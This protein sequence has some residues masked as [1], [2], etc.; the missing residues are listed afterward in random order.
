MLLYKIY[1]LGL[2]FKCGIFFHV[3]KLLPLH[4][5][6]LELIFCNFSGKAHKI[7]EVKVLS[8]FHIKLIASVII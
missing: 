2:T 3:K 4:G 5:D 6:H 7:L 1:L 8:M